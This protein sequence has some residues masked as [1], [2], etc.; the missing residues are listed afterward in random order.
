MKI[1]KR[2]AV[3][4]FGE[5][6]DRVVELFGSIRVIKSGVVAE[7]V[8][9]VDYIAMCWDY[10][11]EKNIKVK[12]KIKSNT[13]KRKIIKKMERFILAYLGEEDKPMVSLMR[14]RKRDEEN[15]KQR[16]DPEGSICIFW[17]T[18]RVYNSS[19]G[20]HY[21]LVD[22]VRHSDAGC[23]H[24]D[25]YV[26]LTQELPQDFQDKMNEFSRGR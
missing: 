24:W 9:I 7:Q 1:N 11:K 13:T 20:T 26:I 3:V 6:I 16:E 19:V 5:E 14:R 18:H 2:V 21:R 12:I 4:V 25:N 22:N 10:I 23:T 8:N 15:A 17:D